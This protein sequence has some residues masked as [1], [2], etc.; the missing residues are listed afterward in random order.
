MVRV[1]LD[2]RLMNATNMAALAGIV[3]QAI[4]NNPGTFSYTAPNKPPYTDAVF[5]AAILAVINANSEYKL[6]GVTQK[7]ALNKLVV[8]LLAMMNEYAIYVDAIADG[9]EDTILLSGFHVAYGTHPKGK[10]TLPGTPTVTATR[11]DASGEIDAET[12]VYD[13]AVYGCIVSEG[14]ALDPATTITSKGQLIIPIGQT[15][16]VIH[17]VDQHRKKKVDGL[18]QGVNY[19]F[20]YYIINSAGV[21]QLS[22]GFKLM[23]G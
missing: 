22:V 8:I 23:C 3:Q 21:S 5:A 9:N 7:V 17:V 19:W 20:Y 4:K 13:R 1:K 11:A 18:T 10:Q 6:G 16:R 14:K 12:E 15:N 2:F